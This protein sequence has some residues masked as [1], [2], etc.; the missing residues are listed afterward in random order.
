[1]LVSP[2]SQ[3][4]G[5]VNVMMGDGRV[6]FVSE[7]IDMLIWWSIATRDGNEATAGVN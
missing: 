6:Q 4:A 3:H 5:G 7:Q 2:S 1:V